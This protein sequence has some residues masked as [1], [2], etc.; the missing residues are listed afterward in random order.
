MKVTW[1]VQ[2]AAMSL[3]LSGAGR[4][5]S[6][7]NMPDPALMGLCSGLGDA[8]KAVTETQVQALRRLIDATRD[9]DPEKPDMLFRLATLYGTQEQYYSCRARELDAKILDAQSKNDTAAAAQLTTQQQDFEK[10]EKQWQLAA[11]KEFVGITNGPSYASYRKMDQVLFYLSQFL[12]QMKREDQARV[13]FKRLIKDY[14]QS[15]FI[16]NAYLSFGEYFFENKDLENAL[17]FYEKVLQYAGSPVYGYAMYKK[18]WVYYN[19]NDLKNAQATFINVIDFAT[20][21]EK[22]HGNGDAQL[23]KEAKKDLVRTYSQL[24]TP[25]DAWPFFQKHGQDYAPTMLKQLAELYEA[26]GKYTERSVI[27]Q[28]RRELAASPR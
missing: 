22:K 9:A 27:D 18:G 19:L 24:G 20:A 16:P 21:P 3:V 17:K 4:A 14:P 6:E 26:Q 8:A 13:F 2:V 1:H 5:A 7:K 12:T 11:I 25:E 23:A 15:P 28:K 10:R